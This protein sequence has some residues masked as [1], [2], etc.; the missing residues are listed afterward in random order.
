[1]AQDDSNYEPA[2][3]VTEEQVTLADFVVQAR[4]ALDDL[5]D[6]I[7]LDETRTEAEWIEELTNV[8]HNA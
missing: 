6:S 5:S 2:L 1:M 3:R 4:T 7:E 8:I